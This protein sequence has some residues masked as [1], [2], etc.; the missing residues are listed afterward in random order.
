M[1][2]EGNETTVVVSFGSAVYGKGVSIKKAT[3]Q[4]FKSNI[5]NQYLKRNNDLIDENGCILNKETADCIEEILD[6]DKND[7]DDDYDYENVYDNNS[8][9][10]DENEN[11]QS[12]SDNLYVPYKGKRGNRYNA[13][14]I[15]I[16]RRMT[17]VK[18]IIFLFELPKR[19]GPPPEILTVDGDGNLI[20]IVDKRNCQKFFGDHLIT[21][22]LQNISNI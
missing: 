10:V 17:N 7:D 12:G 20:V 22:I 1:K 4:L 11:D 5:Y 18:Q 19:T 14:R 3:Y 15:W 16:K 6:N 9:D 8:Y 21:V 13:Y 2:A